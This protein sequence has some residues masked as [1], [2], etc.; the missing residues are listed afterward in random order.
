MG[1]LGASCPNTPFV[2]TG[3]LEGIGHRLPCPGLSIEGRKAPLPWAGG[4]PRGS[5]NAIS[6]PL[7]QGPRSPGQT[8]GQTT[9]GSLRASQFFGC[10]P[11]ISHVVITSSGGDLASSPNC[12]LAF[13]SQCPKQG[14]E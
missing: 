8:A 10:A 5:A 4:L 1:P 14:W 7:G 9:V 2:V 12:E 3:L 11:R 6:G 13:R